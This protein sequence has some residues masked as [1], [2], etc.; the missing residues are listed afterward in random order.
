MLTRSPFQEPGPGFGRGGDDGADGNA[1]LSVMGE[2]AKIEGKF[3]ITHSLHVECEIGGELEVGGR[4]VIGERGVVRADV[5]TVDALVMGTY[6]GS[7][8]ASGDVEIAAT[9]RVLGNVETDSLVIE[10]GGFFNGTVAKLERSARADLAEKKDASPA[11]V[12]ASSGEAEEPDEEVV[13]GQAA[14][15]D[16]AGARV[17]RERPRTYASRTEFLRSGAES[18]VRSD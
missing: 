16:V 1:L 3:E 4:L 6:E 12:G 11:S 2:R 18:A 17:G 5:R 8:V 15:R 13:V 10:K 14:A 7:M 9:G